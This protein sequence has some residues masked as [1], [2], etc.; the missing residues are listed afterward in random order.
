MF[1][2][3]YSPDED[4]PLISS[5]KNSVIRIVRSSQQGSYTSQGALL[6][7]LKEESP[8]RSEAYSPTNS[9]NSKKLITV[10][11]LMTSRKADNPSILKQLCS[12]DLRVCPIFAV[13][14]SLGNKNEQR[15][16]TDDQEP[17]EYKE[18]L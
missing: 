4:S 10:K 13:D 6:E 14:F 7:E 11:G 12:G 2:E 18:L 9:H 17:N 15:H 1:F 8:T 5:Q 3:P 16:S